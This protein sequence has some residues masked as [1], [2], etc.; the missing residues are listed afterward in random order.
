MKGGDNIGRLTEKQELFC[1]EYIKDLNATQAA[2]RAGYKKKN[3]RII[4]CENLSKPNIKKRIDELKK[5]AGKTE[6]KAIADV[7]EILSFHSRVIRGEEKEPYIYVD[8]LEDGS[9]KA[10]II[11]KPP[12]IKDKQKSA[13]LLGRF[14]GLEKGDG[15][16]ESQETVVFTFERSEE[17]E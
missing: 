15:N 5:K 1:L 9:K 10:V 6:E 16:E 14:Y 8:M 13:E 17:K 11:D 12:Q 2:I 7:N 3:A 4:G